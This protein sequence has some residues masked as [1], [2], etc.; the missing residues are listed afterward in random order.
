ME[1]VMLAVSSTVQ[2][3]AIVGLVV[4]LVV[5]VVVVLLLQMTLS[6][7]RKVLADVTSANTAPMLQRG[8]PGTDQLGQ[9]RRLA[10][11]VPPLALAYLQKLGAG[12]P[13][14]APAPPPAA[15]FPEPS[16]SQPAWQRYGR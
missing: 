11:S 4:G 15:I 12:A 5:L 10:E 8:V 3:L 9:T 16:G 14:A 6:P 1:E 2:I 7:L 13:P